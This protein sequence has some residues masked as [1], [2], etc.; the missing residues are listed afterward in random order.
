[1]R[2]NGI[3]GMTE[4]AHRLNFERAVVSRSRRK[5]THKNDRTITVIAGR[6]KKKTFYHGLL[7][8]QL[9]LPSADDHLV[10]GHIEQQLRK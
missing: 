9:N 4:I 8:V 1:M 2:H 7:F 5:C 10:P 3:R 6:T